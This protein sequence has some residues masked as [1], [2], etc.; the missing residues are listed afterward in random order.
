MHSLGQIIY[1]QLTHS[2]GRCVASF[3]AADGAVRHVSAGELVE[4]AFGVA[5]AIRDSE[6]PQ[7]SVVGVALYSGAAL[8]AAWLGCLW[9]GHIPTM[10]APPSPRMEPTKY[11]AGLDGMIRHL[12]LAAMLVDQISAEGFASTIADMI[13]FLTV[14]GLRKAGAGAVAD[15]AADEVVVLQHSSGTTGL[16]KGVMLTTR[17]ILAHHRAYAERIE[18]SPA[19]QIVSWL[20]L[21]HDMGFVASFLLPMIAGLPV[22][23]MSPFAWASR[24]ADLLHVIDQ[25]RPTLCWM[26]NFAFALLSGQ[27]VRSSLRPVDLSSVRAWI[28]CSEPVMASSIDRFVDAL[29]GYG[30]TRESVLASYA[31]AENVFAV[32]QCVPGKPRVIAVDRE[33]LEHKHLA[34]IADERISG[35]QRFVSNGEC[36]PTT[37][38]QVRDS[39]GERLGEGYV[40]ELWIRGDHRFFGYFNRPDLTALCIDDEGWFSTGDVGFTLDNHVYVTGRKKD[41]VIVRGRN[42]HCHDIEQ[43]AG[44]VE[45]VRPGRAVAFSVPDEE[46]GTEKLVVLAEAEPGYESS[47]GSIVL[48]IRRRISQ[49]LDTTAADVRIV[50]PRWLVKS[51]AGKLARLDNREKYLATVRAEL[52]D[53]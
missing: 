27:R 9:S 33:M 15:F 50:P 8:H 24:P 16:Q 45:G 53:V 13:P 23:E 22:I 20:P 29:S 36:L 4:M 17:Q 25:F 10:I 38:L 3:V 42:F 30:V 5:S 46:A 1:G 41:I 6:I 2:P 43:L 40:G 7:R 51:T 26:P 18:L 35:T 32:T 49:A 52:A 34:V 19:D 39:A 28:N 47:D 37:R 12:G 21:Y 48:N 44:D 14:D 31:M 11:A